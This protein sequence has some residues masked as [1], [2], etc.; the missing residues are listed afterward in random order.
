MTD[1]IVSRALI[2][3]GAMAE[4]WFDAAPSISSGALLTTSKSAS[5]H[6]EQGAKR[7]VEGL[8]RIETLKLSM[9]KD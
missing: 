4:Q 9:S 2:E 1:V 6:P 7:R 3:F 8:G 5:N